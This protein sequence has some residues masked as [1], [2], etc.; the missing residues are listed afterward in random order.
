[1]ERLKFTVIATTFFLVCTLV[2]MGFRQGV[3]HPAAA[4]LYFM[5]G[6]PLAWMLY[7]RIKEERNQRN[8]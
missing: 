8:Q 5:L 3:M 1:M 2:F 7:T 6:Y 4:S